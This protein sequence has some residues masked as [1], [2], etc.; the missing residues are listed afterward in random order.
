MLWLTSVLASV[1][2]ASNTAQNLTAVASIVT[3][4]GLLIT[5]IA[6]LVPILRTTKATHGL[7]NQQHTDLVNYQA[8]LIRAMRAA[9][10]DVPMDQSAPGPAAPTTE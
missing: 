7:V 2:S 3:A 6:L 8:A 1:V 5:A 10:I 4:F 9:G